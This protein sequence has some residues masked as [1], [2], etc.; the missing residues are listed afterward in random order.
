MLKN[1][2]LKYGAIITEP[3]F[4]VSVYGNSVAENENAKQSSF[5][6]WI[7]GISEHV[8]NYGFISEGSKEEVI[9]P[10]VKEEI[11][12]E[13]KVET[14]ADV[15]T[16]E[17]AKSESKEEVKEDSKDED[18]DKA[19][20]ETKVEIKEEAKTESKEEAHVNGNTALMLV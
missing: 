11:K 8:T 2:D 9:E 5:N 7:Q 13:T 14:K 1:A 16:K 10:E 6:A 12:V 20:V 19:E 3:E 18:E 4:M 17:E 15:E